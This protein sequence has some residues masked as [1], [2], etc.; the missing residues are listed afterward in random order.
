MS[1][2]ARLANIERLLDA[3]GGEALPEPLPDAIHRAIDHGESVDEG[4]LTPGQRRT[5]ETVLAMVASV[6]RFE[7]SIDDAERR[8]E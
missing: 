4:T 5:R 3:T 2:N 8:A 6:P 7:G 1:V